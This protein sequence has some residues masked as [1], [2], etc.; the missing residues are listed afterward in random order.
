MVIQPITGRLFNAQDAQMSNKVAVINETMARRF[1][2]NGSAIGRRFGI[3]ETP[4]H[5]GEKEVV[6]VVKDGEVDSL[7]E[8]TQM[9]AY[10][11]CTQYPG[12]Y[13]NFAVR[14]ALGANR[15]EIISRARRA[16]AEVNP[17]ILVSNVGSLEEQVDG[18]IAINV[19]R[20][21]GIGSRPTTPLS[22]RN[23]SIPSSRARPRTGRSRAWMR[24]RPT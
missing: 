15:Q 20:G 12:F 4:D 16:I 24:S 9:A 14:Y 19:S 17:N 23:A 8:G 18:S 21:N 2:P 3:R 10:F 22:F 13:G 7:T 6:G 5:P 1:F 11:P